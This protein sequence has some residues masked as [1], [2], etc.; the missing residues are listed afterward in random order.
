MEN[1]VRFPH[2]LKSE[3]LEGLDAGFKKDFLNK[4]AV[5]TFQVA[6]LILDQ[7]EPSDGMLL[8]AHGY[9]DIT[10]VGEDGQQLFLTRSRVGAT[11]GETEAISDEPCAA[12]CTAAKNTTILFCAKPLLIQSLQSFGFIKNMTKVFNKRLV[13]DNSFKH[14]AQFGAVGQRLRGYL[15][16]LSENASRIVE[17]Q[18]YLANVVG[19]SRQTIN[20]ELAKLRD[21]GLIEQKGSEIII[22]DRAAIGE[23]LMD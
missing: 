10:Y 1:C 13:N 16:M 23:G 17:T 6:T 4:C 15:Y 11:L 12:T 2:L 20:R 19:C 8:I 22:L 3:I 18:S 14:I 5:K 7:G 9:V 21:D